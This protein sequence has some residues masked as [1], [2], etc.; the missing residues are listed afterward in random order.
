M[1]I[2][3]QSIIEGVINKGAGNKLFGGK[4]A[5]GPLR[6]ADFV[7]EVMI[8]VALELTE[9]LPM[10]FEQCRQD[11][12]LKQK[13][14][15]EHTK[16]GKFTDSYGWTPDGEFRHDIDIDPV[17]FN[18][19]NRIIV[20]FMGGAKKRWNDENSKIWN[21]VKKL[22]ISGDKDKIARLQQS[23]K[24]NILKESKRRIISG[25]DGSNIIQP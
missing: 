3:M 11:Y 21:Y 10:L 20:P 4:R 7:Y 1:N 2:S 25:S 22:I 18:Y 5:R 9:R 14:N 8:G 17:L 23:I 6:T 16:K 12:E 19:F 15:K 13:W 24:R